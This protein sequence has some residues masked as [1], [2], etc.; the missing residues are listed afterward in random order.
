MTIKDVYFPRYYS[1]ASWLESADHLLRSPSRDNAAGLRVCHLLDRLHVLLGEMLL[2]RWAAM[3]SFCRQIAVS[4]DG[5]A[6]P[7]IQVFG[8]S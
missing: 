1:P 2:S 8:V 5:A 3:R 6:W 7:G 4:Y